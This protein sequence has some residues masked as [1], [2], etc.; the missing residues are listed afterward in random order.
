M[1]IEQAAEHHITTV[2]TPLP[3]YSSSAL[4]VHHFSFAHTMTSNDNADEFIAQQKAIMSHRIAV[5]RAKEEAAQA[6]ELENEKKKMKKALAEKLAKMGPQ[7]VGYK[8]GESRRR[9]KEARK[10][11]E[12]F[13]QK[14]KEKEGGGGGRGREGRGRQKRRMK[15]R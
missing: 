2:A 12:E 6:E 5:A 11:V 4:P 1:L 3:H 15:R 13:E 10:K 14:M 8:V 9:A 7:I